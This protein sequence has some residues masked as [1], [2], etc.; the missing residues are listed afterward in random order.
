MEGTKQLR[1]NTPDQI[2]TRLTSSIGK[3]IQVVLNNGT[4]TMGKL[5]EITTTSI[6]LKHMRLQ[7]LKFEVSAIAEVY[8]DHVV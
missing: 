4:I 3:T 1:L 7:K 6:T 5:L 2:K 8:I